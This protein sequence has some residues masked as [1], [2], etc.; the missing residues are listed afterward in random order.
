MKTMLM[1]KQI[2]SMAVLTFGAFL[3]AVLWIW[4][5]PYVECY[6]NEGT[7]VYYVERNSNFFV[8]DFLFAFLMFI[9]AVVVA[10]SFKRSLWQAGIYV[11]LGVSAYAILLSI[12]VALLGQFIR[13]LTMLD[14]LRADAG[15]ELRTLGAIFILPAVLQLIVTITGMAGGTYSKAD[16]SVE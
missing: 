2:Q 8:A 14:D 10:L 7:C 1:S 11:Q 9:L 15:L 12:L 13:P 3:V 5:A 16:E 6:V 4:L